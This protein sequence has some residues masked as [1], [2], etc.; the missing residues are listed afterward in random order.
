MDT[1]NIKYV[2]L[3][4]TALVSTIGCTNIAFAIFNLIFDVI[5]SVMI[6]LMMQTGIPYIGYIYFPGMVFTVYNI[7]YTLFPISNDNVIHKAMVG[8]SY[9]ISI[10]A[11]AILAAAVYYLFILP[12]NSDSVF[13]AFILYITAIGFHAIQAFIFREYSSTRD[14]QEAKRETTKIVDI[15]GGKYNAVTNKL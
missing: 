11:S 3:H 14:T 7:V 9:L 1:N 8:L 13:G 12:G 15:E 10:V 2:R 4:P 6:R 5:W